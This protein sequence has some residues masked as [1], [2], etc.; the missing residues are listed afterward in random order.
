VVQDIQFDGETMYTISDASRRNLL[1]SVVPGAR[2]TWPVGEKFGRRSTFLS[3]KDL[4]RKPLPQLICEQWELDSNPEFN[5]LILQPRATMQSLARRWVQKFQILG[6]THD[7]LAMLSPQPVQLYRPVCTD[8]G[9]AYLC[10]HYLYHP[11]D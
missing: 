2:L 1:Q 7:I 6:H 8:S 5:V 4:S 10:L 3:L 11:A 9:K